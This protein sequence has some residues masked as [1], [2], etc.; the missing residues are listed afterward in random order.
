MAATSSSGECMESLMPFK[1][2]GR[3]ARLG[4]AYGPVLARVCDRRSLLYVGRGL[5]ALCFAKARNRHLTPATPE[6]SIVAGQR[7]LSPLAAAGR[8]DPQ[9]RVTSPVCSR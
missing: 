8:T 2:A 7:P 4:V 6:V 1:C 3:D 9:S 5:G